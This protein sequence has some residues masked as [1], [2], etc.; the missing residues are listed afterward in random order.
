[1]RIRSVEA[2]PYRIPYR[3]AFRMATASMPAAEH[4]LVRIATDDGVVG[5][6][7]APARPMIYGESQ[8]SIVMAI[9]QW[10]APAI[11][12]MDPF[13]VE[14]LRGRLAAVVHNNT[15]KAAIDI[16]LHDLQGKALGQPCW[17]LLGAASES[18]AVS[19]MLSMGE[20]GEVAAEARALLDGL[21]IRSFKVKIDADVAAHTAVLAAVREEVGPQCTLYADA[22]R[23]MR[24]E[25]VLR[26]VRAAAE[27]DLRFVEDPTPVEDTG[28]RRFLAEHMD[29][30]LLA[31]EAATTLGAAGRELLAGTARAVSVKVART[32][33][34]DSR[35][36]V[37][38]AE[39]MHA[40]V[41]IGSQGDAAVGTA[42][43]LAFGA[44]HAATAAHACEIDFYRHLEDDI[45]TEP[46]VIADGRMAVDPTAP[47]IGVAIDEDKLAHYQVHPPAL[48]SVEG[49][50]A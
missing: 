45:V 14:Q 50:N 11:L 21:G 46:P 8:A 48:T 10:F 13:A 25:E 16:A 1:M 23:S 17:R 43:A 41:L 27:L 4:V 28:G 29:I 9:R 40:S 49:D 7:E 2:V 15:A 3:T 20:P 19:S 22:N 47:G 36:L 34:T 24:A 37:G 44:A 6:A 33:F 18:V 12:G 35:K 42:A 31:D 32:G 39:G 26:L 5:V 30:P 38:L